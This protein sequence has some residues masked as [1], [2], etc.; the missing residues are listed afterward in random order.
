MPVHKSA[1]KRVKQNKK[2]YKRSM[3]YRTRLKKAI[4]SF[5]SIDKADEAKERF[6]ELVSIID[7][8]RQKGII[9]KRK[10]SRMKSRLSRH[11]SPS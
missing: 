6:P 11:R 1:E 2:R 7:K 3:A 4:R 9:K 10:A 8:S 5:K